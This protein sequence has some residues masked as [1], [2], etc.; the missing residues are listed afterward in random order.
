MVACQC[1][2]DRADE[3]EGAAVPV[4]GAS[5]DTSTV[6]ERQ[7]VVAAERCELMCACV[8][9]SMPGSVDAN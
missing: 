5:S 3:D 2:L 6:S 1:P 9:C 8:R 4:A 7:C